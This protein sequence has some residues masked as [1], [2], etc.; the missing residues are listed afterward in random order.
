M[1]V[2]FLAESPQAFPTI[3]FFVLNGSRINASLFIFPNG[4]Y[5]LGLGE[6]VDNIEGSFFSGFQG[7]VLGGVV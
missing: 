4:L 6:T 1:L 3:S 5:P 7:R 2:D